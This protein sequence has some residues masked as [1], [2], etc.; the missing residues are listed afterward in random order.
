MAL[1]V[2]AVLL[3]L[4]GRGEKEGKTVDWPAIGLLLPSGTGM[5]QSYHRMGV[6]LQWI[7]AT[8]GVRTE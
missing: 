1:R 3:V 4:A 7:G 2:L 5:G 6:Q 8:P